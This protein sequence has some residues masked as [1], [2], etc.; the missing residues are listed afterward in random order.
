[1]DA[2]LLALRLI[3]LSCF[4][5]Q[6]LHANFY[7]VRF[8]EGDRCITSVVLSAVMSMAPSRLDAT[9]ISGAAKDAT[10]RDNAGQSG[11]YQC[12]KWGLM[13]PNRPERC[14][15][16]TVTILEQSIVVKHVK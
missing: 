1:M 5:V 4:V 15:L 8:A 6:I 9:Y 11:C 10:A 3:F 12:P 7:L 14:R 16:T 13:A 2:E